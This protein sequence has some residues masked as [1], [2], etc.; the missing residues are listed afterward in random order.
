MK[1]SPVIKA[2]K[3]LSKAKW[4]RRHYQTKAFYDD[5]I[6]ANAGDFDEMVNS[7]WAG[8]VLPTQS[9][10]MET[11]ATTGAQKG[12]HHVVVTRKL[13]RW[14]WSCRHVKR[15]SVTASTEGILAH[16]IWCPAEEVSKLPIK[17]TIN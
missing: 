5:A 11:L 15:P 1:T 13:L 8:V 17:Y 7:C 2:K 10:L 16:I 6:R 3:V 14:A 4:L 9:P 12:P